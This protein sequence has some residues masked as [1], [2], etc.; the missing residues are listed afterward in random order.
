VS[1]YFNGANRCKMLNQYLGFSE[2]LSAQRY[3]L[4]S[5]PYN[6]TKVE[7]VQMIASEM[8]GTQP[9][10]TWTEEPGSLPMRRSRGPGR[11]R[12]LVEAELASSWWARVGKKIRQAMRSLHR[13][14]ATEFP[15][16]YET[17]C[18]RAPSAPAGGVGDC[19]DTIEEF[20]YWAMMSAD[21]SAPSM[22]IQSDGFAT[23][24]K[25]G[26]D[27]PALWA[28]SAR[29]D[30]G[31]AGVGCLDTS[32]VRGSDPRQI[33]RDLSQLDDRACGY[34][35]AGDRSGEGEIGPWPSGVGRR[36]LDAADRGSTTFDR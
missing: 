8:L 33:P 5:L 24:E 15:R 32:R 19:A 22:G 27:S 9:T 4:G 28:L 29:A 6:R 18:S 21:P 7:G 16:W 23:S 13:P 34:E 1:N 10:C 30:S 3:A 14:P 17:E 2:V 36:R 20:L 11:L 25:K 12:Y 26:S 31:P 35:W